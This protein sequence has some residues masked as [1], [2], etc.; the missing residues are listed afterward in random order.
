MWGWFSKS[1]PRVPSLQELYTQ[2]P[3][4]PQRSEVEREMLVQQ[5]LD[6]MYELRQKIN[7]ALLDANVSI[8]AH[9]LVQAEVT[10]WAKRWNIEA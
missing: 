3:Q 1:V 4:W 8:E 10:A 9:G 7:G 5:R 2:P 6:A